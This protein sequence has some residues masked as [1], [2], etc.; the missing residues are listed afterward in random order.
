MTGADVAVYDAAVLG[1]VTGGVEAEIGLIFVA[2][3]AAMTGVIAVY[4]AVVLGLATRDISGAVTGV[5][6]A[7]GCL[8]GWVGL[9]GAFALFCANNENLSELAARCAFCADSIA[10]FA[11]SVASAADFADSFNMISNDIC[12]VGN[13]FLY[14]LP[15]TR[16]KKYI[17]DQHAQ[18]KLICTLTGFK[19]RDP[20][21]SITTRLNRVT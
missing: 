9:M 2:A 6:V 14:R 13:R 7:N 20:F 3:T 17:Y 12:L 1:M 8:V 16:N 19:N 4:V 18:V 15:D 5:V 21:Y 11:A 10:D